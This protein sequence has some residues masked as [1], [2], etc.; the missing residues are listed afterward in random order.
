MLPVLDA[1]HSTVSERLM[2]LQTMKEQVQ[3]R[4]ANSNQ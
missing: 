4:L 1:G 3:Q 2:M